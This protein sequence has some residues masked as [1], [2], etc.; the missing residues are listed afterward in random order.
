MESKSENVI[1]FPG[2]KKALEEESLKA[3]QEKKYEEALKKL[4]QLISYH[5][6]TYEIII[7]KLICL[8]ELGRHEEAQ[9]LCEDLIQHKDENYYHYVHIYLTIL[10]QTSQYSLLMEQ[11]EYEFE[12][13][14][15]P[16]ILHEQFK[17]LHDMSEQMKLDFTIEN[18]S[19]II[20]ELFAAVNQDNHVEQWNIVA[21]LRSMK[22][23]P[24]SQVLSLLTNDYVHPVIKT[25]LLDWMKD[26]KISDEVEIH[27]FSISM[28][29]IPSE[30]PDLKANESFKE[31]LK[32]MQ[33]VEQNNPT[34]FQLLE[35]L[36]YRYIY[37]IYPFIP[38][39]GDVVEIGKAIK[40][41]GSQYLQL[42]TNQ[43]EETNTKVQH[44]MKEIRMCD[45]LY[46]SIIEE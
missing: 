40:N 1:L 42:H 2:L 26:N 43:N 14:N 31:I 46:L 30:I 25:A 7:G 34:L 41:I 36:L 12:Q 32:V 5:E 15:V 6:Y 10:F 11:V 8:M 45:S 20:D 18:S 17:Q 16:D 35:Q 19:N 4:N 21:Q 37:V 9:D 29:V 23:Q 27:K 39:D 28:S 38:P 3:L 24:V 33:D 44:Y 22:A 13:N